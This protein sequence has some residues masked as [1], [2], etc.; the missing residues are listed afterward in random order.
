MTAE[1][2]ASFEAPPLQRLGATADRAT[3]SASIVWTAT[4]V[5]AAGL[6]YYHWRYEGWR[7]T[8]LFAGSV[9]AALVFALTFFSRRILFSITLIALLVATIVIASGIKRH[10]IEMV[11]HSYDVVFYLTSWPTLVYLWADHKPMLLALFGMVAITAGSGLVLWQFDGTRIPRQVSGGLFVFCACL[12][13]WS[14]YAKGERKNTLFYWDNLYVS[15]FYSS[16]SETLETLWKGQLLD[17]LSSQPKPPFKIP[18]TCDP[19]EKPPH[20]I[21][22]HQESVVPP[23]YFPEIAYDRTL[24]PFF[25][26]FDGQT[27]QAACRNLWRGVVAD[28]IFRSRR[29]LDLLLRW[30]ADVRAVPDAGKNSRHRAASARALRLPQQRLLPGAERFRFQRPLLRDDRDARDF[31]L[32]GPGRQAIQ[33]ARPLLLCERPRQHRASHRAIEQPAVHI[34]HHVGDAPSLSIQV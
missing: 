32:Q 20:I 10:Y 26:S 23:S 24:D 22:I 16:W 9:T 28:R 15:S 4:A 17:A 12:G 7:E 31:R 3:L 1:P 6:A 19:S 33:R 34:H 25:K 30:H 2:L 11:L 18:A 8:I 29:R 14:S 13:V 5:I 21:L 27:S